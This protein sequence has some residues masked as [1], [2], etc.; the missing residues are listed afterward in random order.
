MGLQQTAGHGRHPTDLA[1]QTVGLINAQYGDGFGLPIWHCIR[2][3][4]PK[5]NL[6]APVVCCGVR[7]FGQLQATGQK[8]NAPIY[9][10]QTLLAIDVIAIF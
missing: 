3:T 2:H 10:A 4:G 7:D 6:I 5:K 8:T 1:L 9:F